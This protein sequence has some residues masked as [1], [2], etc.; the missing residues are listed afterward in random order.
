MLRVLTPSRILLNQ[1]CNPWLHI[2]TRLW[3][4][5]H[6]FAFWNWQWGGIILSFI[7]LSKINYWPLKNIYISVTRISDTVKHVRYSACYGSYVSGSQI[8][9]SSDLHVGRA[10]RR[11]H[12]SSSSLNLETKASICQG[13]STP[14]L[15]RSV[16]YHNYN[17]KIQSLIISNI[18]PHRLKKHSDTKVWENNR[19]N[20][21]LHIS[22]KSRRFDFLTERKCWYRL[23]ASPLKQSINQSINYMQLTSHHSISVY[24][25][26]QDSG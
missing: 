15:P 12:P 7:R 24:C 16:E 8:L 20:S 17:K 25:C 5:E 6:C 23:A 2:S 9:F 26:N 13:Q 22:F 21:C 1:N 3:T 19:P 10:V 4:L 18:V 14:F 11:P